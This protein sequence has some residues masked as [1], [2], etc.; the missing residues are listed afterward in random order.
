MF[1]ELFSYYCSLQ[2]WGAA[3]IDRLRPMQLHKFRDVFEYAR[4]HSKFYRNLYKEH[5]ILNL[6]INS[7]DD[8]QK[9]PIINKTM[10]RNHDIRDIMTCE[11]DSN[12]NIHSTSGSTGEPLK[13]AYSKFEDYASHVRLTTAMMKYGYNPFKK[14]VLLSR[15]E[16]GH[17]FEVESDLKKLNLIQRLFP[18]FRREVISIFDPVTTIIEKLKKYNPYVLWS[19][20]SVIHLLAMELER[21]K[22]RLEIPLIVTMAETI[23]DDQLAL[24]RNRICLNILDVYGCMESPSMGFS[25][26]SV[27]YKNIVSDSTLAEVINP[28]DMNGFRVG[29]VIITNLI[30]KT[31]PFI[32]YDLGDFVEVLDDRQFPNKKIGRIHGRFD[33]IITLD[34]GETLS[35]HQT[36]QLF[37]DF[38]QCKQYKFLQRKNGDVILQLIVEPGVNKDTVAV[39]VMD[40]WHAKFPGAR[41]EIEWVDS[42]KIDARTGKFKVLERERT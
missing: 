28:R 32:R 33:D 30:N 38:H 18:V 14:L 39:A 27:G 11:I 3:S 22:Q 6:K 41:L 36:Y 20:P 40:R 4:A 2:Y 9:V 8:V 35:F 21:Q 29:D 17:E 25:Y 34:N 5:G 42:F 31:M 15:Y 26:N 23:S 7:W 16:P 24:F 1:L 10:I 13:I 19:T 12:I 37:H